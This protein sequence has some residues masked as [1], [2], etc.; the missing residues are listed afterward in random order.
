[1]IKKN[2]EYIVNI[3]DNG[4]NGEGICKIDEFTIFVNGAIKDEKCKIKIVKVN[5]SFGYGKLLEII[6]ASPNRVVPDCVSYKK[7]GGCNLRHL[8]YEYT[9]KM[10]QEKIQ[11][12][13]NKTLNNKI[14]VS[15]TLGM[16]IPKYYRNKA[17][18]PVKEIDGKKV[19]GIFANRSHEVI[20]FED[21]KIQSKEAQQIAKYIVETWTGTIYNEQTN[22]GTLRNIMIRVGSIS[23]EIMVVLVTNGMIDYDIS[24]LIKQFPNIKTIIINDNH[25]VTNVVLSNTNKTIYGDGV[26]YD[27]L[28][29]YKFQISPNSF[30]QVNSIQT[31]NM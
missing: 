19:V 23:K 1:M 30:F 5:K 28:N 11:N 7:C 15:K 27:Y 9:L 12:L 26:I 29:E 22:K 6:E 13:V 20:E 16:D 3:I 21:C 4:S 24:G 8:K 31:I 2:E 25:E 17:I 14:Q 18:F 10:K